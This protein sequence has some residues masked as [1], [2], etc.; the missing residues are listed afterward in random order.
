MIFISDKQ[1]ILDNYETLQFECTNKVGLVRDYL[2]KECGFK[3]DNWN[4]KDFVYINWLNIKKSNNTVQ[5]NTNPSNTKIKC[6]I[7]SLLGISIM[8]LHEYNLV[9]LKE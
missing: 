6:N 3:H 2:E 9:N 7:D 8:D 4:T 5:G 1:Y